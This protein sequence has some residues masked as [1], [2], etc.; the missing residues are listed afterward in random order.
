[1]LLV[2]C[3]TA[4]YT[5]VG[6]RLSQSISESLISM[7]FESGCQTAFAPTIRANTE[8]LYIFYRL[9]ESWGGSTGLW[10]EKQQPLCF[11]GTQFRPQNSSI[12][13]CYR[14]GFW[15]CPIP[16]LDITGLQYDLIPCFYK[17]IRT[18]HHYNQWKVATAFDAT[19]G[20]FVY[21]FY[22]K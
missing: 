8:H 22:S 3:V 7:P 5:G 2:L 20:K 9:G 1:M 11:F 14:V 6:H 10:T 18:Y 12:Q 17:L 15:F 13:T 16:R 21:S 19:L 4:E